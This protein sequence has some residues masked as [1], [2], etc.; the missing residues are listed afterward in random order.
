[1]PTVLNVWVRTCQDYLLAADSC[2]GL[3]LDL[4]LPAENVHRDVA[5][6]KAMSKVVSASISL[7]FPEK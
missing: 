1:M 6:G 7:W 2:P 5:T 4:S 3:V